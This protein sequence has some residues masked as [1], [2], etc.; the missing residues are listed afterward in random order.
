MELHNI[1]DPY[2]KYIRSKINNLLNKKDTNLKNTIRIN[3]SFINL[4]KNAQNGGGLGDTDGTGGT[5]FTKPGNVQNLVSTFENINAKENSQKKTNTPTQEVQSPATRL[6]PPT[7]LTYS[8]NTSSTDGDIDSDA[9]DNLI[10]EFYGNLNKLFNEVHRVN[11][12]YHKYSEALS[13]LGTNKHDVEQFNEQL[14][15]MDNLLGEFKNI[16]P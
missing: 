5:N 7:Q 1:D 14:K 12:E 11:T 2:Y 16:T 6:P 3:N 4:L 10:R 15:I 9:V 13:D 8:N